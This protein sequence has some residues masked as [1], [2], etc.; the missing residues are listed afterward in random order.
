MQRETNRKL[1]TVS[2]PLRPLP[3]QSGALA[4]GHRGAD[5]AAQIA[6]NVTHK[7]GCEGHIIH[8]EYAP[9]PKSAVEVN[10]KNVREGHVVNKLSN[11]KPSSTLAHTHRYAITQGSVILEN[12]IHQIPNPRYYLGSPVNVT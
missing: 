5:K 7:I 8:C 6:A 2:L 4:R 12:R 1:I 10:A 3:E 11:L 9:K